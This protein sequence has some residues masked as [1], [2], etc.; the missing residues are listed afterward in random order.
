MSVGIAPISDAVYDEA[1]LKITFTR[2]GTYVKYAVLRRWNIDFYKIEL[3]AG[4]NTLNLQSALDHDGQWEL[5]AE[6]ENSGEST[7]FYI[8]G[9]KPDDIP[10][11]PVA[12]VPTLTP[13][14]LTSNTYHTSQ[15]GFYVD[16][17]TETDWWTG[18]T[19]FGSINNVT[20]TVIFKGIKQRYTTGNQ[21]VIFLAFEISNSEGSGV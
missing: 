8:F 19:W 6:D 1:N 12:S 17:T 2:P 7:P 16:P 20:A 15:I 5:I 13:T 4:T 3:T 14:L 9:E 21:I 18:L 11:K 10:A